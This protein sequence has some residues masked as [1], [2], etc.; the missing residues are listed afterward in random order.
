MKLA[1]TLRKKSE[2]L[3]IKDQD[4]KLKK[5]QEV[6]E[7]F[8]EK[9]AEEM[10]QELLSSLDKIPEECLKT[11]QYKFLLQHAATILPTEYDGPTWAR[12]TPLG[13]KKKYLDFLL[14]KLKNEGFEVKE[15]LTK[16]LMYPD[17]QITLS[18]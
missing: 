1:D 13:E 2:D 3:K 10:W 5:R 11:G 7:L 9:F 16:S 17:Y 15:E 14:P 6:G 12:K 8:T 4:Q 18:W